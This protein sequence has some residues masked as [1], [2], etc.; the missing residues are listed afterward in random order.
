MTYGDS[1]WLSAQALGCS[2]EILADFWQT[3][4][5]VI[6]FTYTFSPVEVV[7]HFRNYFG[8]TQKAF[9]ALDEN[10]Q[11]ALRRDLEQLW[12]EN[13]QATDGTT[14]GESEYLEVLAVRS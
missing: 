4:L 1:T 8:P 2:Y 9:D 7:E 12:A 11:A 13:Y 10:G 5:S 3:R 6:T 14:I